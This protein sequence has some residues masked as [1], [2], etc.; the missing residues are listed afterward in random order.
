[1]SNP[2]TSHQILFP[3]VFKTSPKSASPIFEIKPFTIKRVDNYNNQLPTKLSSATS[4]RKLL[5]EHNY[6]EFCINSPKF[7]IDTM[8]SYEY[9][10]SIDKLIEYKIKSTNVINMSNINGVCEGLEFRIVEMINRTGSITERIKSI[11]TKRYPENKIK[12][13]LLNCLLDI[14][15]KDVIEAKNNN[16][17]YIKLLA[18]NKNKTRLLSFLPSDILVTNKKDFI[19]LN[20]DAKKVIEFDFNA[21]KVYSCVKD[22]YDALSD[23]KIGFKKV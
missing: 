2:A 14:T 1:M 15:K 21:S 10:S 23:F 4:L 17:S 11:N 6:N 7:A 22:K 8:S 12:R 3:C 13:I 18:I 16:S 20:E 5:T 19:K 9:S